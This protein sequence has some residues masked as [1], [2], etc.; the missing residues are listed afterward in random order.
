MLTLDKFEEASEKVKEATAETKLIYSEFFS[1]QCGNKVYLKPEN[2]QFVPDYKVNLVAPYSMSEEEIAQFHTSFRELMLFIKYSGDKKK[3]QEIVMKDKHF[4]S[5]Q[6]EVVDVINVV[7]DSK[8]TYS[9]E[10]E[11]VDM[12]KAILDMR[13]ESRHEGRNSGQAAGLERCRRYPRGC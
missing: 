7:T 4:H 13:N 9:Q 3:L 5:M 11:N 2:L 6:R 8:L 10:E 1:S 12:C